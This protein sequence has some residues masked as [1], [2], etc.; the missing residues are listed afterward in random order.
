MGKLS[1]IT[2]RI[3]SK[4]LRGFGFEFFREAKGS[5]EIWYNEHSQRY[6]TIPKHGGDMAEGTLR[7]ILKQAGVEVED[8]L[9]S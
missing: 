1:G 3:L 6:T 9:K 4:K 5:H 2:Y 8:F 7:A